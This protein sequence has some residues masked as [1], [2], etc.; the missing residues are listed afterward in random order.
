MHKLMKRLCLLVI[1]VGAF[2]LAGHVGMWWENFHSNPIGGSAVFSVS[3][4]SIIGSIFKF[5]HEI[6][7]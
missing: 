5:W 4:L 1:F 3:F 6:F 2:Y 7:T